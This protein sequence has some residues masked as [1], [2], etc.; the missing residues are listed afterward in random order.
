[1]KIG[2]NPNTR[3]PAQ[4]GGAFLYQEA[5]LLTI[6]SDLGYVLRCNMKFDICILELS[7]KINLSRIQNDIIALTYPNRMVFW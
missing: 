3:L 6:Q 1:M 2:N 4:V 5:D 7:G